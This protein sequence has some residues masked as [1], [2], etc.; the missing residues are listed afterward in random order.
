MAALLPFSHGLAANSANSSQ[1]SERHSYTYC[2]HILHASRLV[3][4]STG[5][6][7]P[8]GQAMHAVPLPNVKLALLYVPGEHR[9]KHTGIVTVGFKTQCKHA[10]RAGLGNIM[11]LGALCK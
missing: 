7:R 4:P 9:S 10:V 3:A 11:E 5:V 2:T 8:V 6:V 1:C